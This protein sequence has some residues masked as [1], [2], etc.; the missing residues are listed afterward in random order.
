MGEQIAITI[1]ESIDVD[2]SAQL[3]MVILKIEIL[4]EGE[5]EPADRRSFLHFRVDPFEAIALGRLLQ[6][7]SMKLLLS[8]SGWDVSA[9][10]F[11]KTDER[12]H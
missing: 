6:D 1:P 10:T 9:G 3:G 5:G 2:T 11:P 8:L 4:L 7:R 12:P